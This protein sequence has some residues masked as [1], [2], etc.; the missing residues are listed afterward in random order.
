[1]SMPKL[2]VMVLLLLLMASC[3]GCLP[4]PRRVECLEVRV[5]ALE[6]ETGRAMEGVPIRAVYLAIPFHLYLNGLFTPAEPACRGNAATTD[7][8]G[9]ATVRVD[10]KYRAEFVA[11]LVEDSRFGS[12][13]TGYPAL[14]PLPLKS[15][16][17]QWDEGKRDAK[18]AVIWL[19]PRK[20]QSRD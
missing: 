8:E 6:W 9:R 10:V 5:T 16:A 18:E 20:T 7:S 12:A 11:V 2:V 19:R 14:F 15:W 4:M 17:R 3:G 13:G 1:M